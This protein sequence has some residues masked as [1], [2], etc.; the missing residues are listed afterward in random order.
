MFLII[1]EIDNVKVPQKG[2]LIHMAQF[3]GCLEFKKNFTE[4]LL[5]YS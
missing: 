5:R 3:T 2:S 1:E 4:K